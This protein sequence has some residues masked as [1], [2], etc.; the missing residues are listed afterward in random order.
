MAAR[1]GRGE[2]LEALLAHGAELEFPDKG[3]RTALFW[4]IYKHQRRSTDLLLARGADPGAMST[5]F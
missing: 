3:N 5:D 2:I 1:D 4:A